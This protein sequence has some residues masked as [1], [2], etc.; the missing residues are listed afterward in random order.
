VGA[1]HRADR[2]VGRLDRLDPVAQGLVDGVLE[3]R[4]AGGHRPDLGAEQPHPDH[5]E[6]LA[7]GV[8]L[9]HVD[10]ALLAEEG[11]DGGGGHTVLAGAGLGDHPRLA[12]PA[13]QQVLA[14]GVVELVGA[15]VEQVLPL[16]PH[17]HAQLLREPPGLEQRGRAAGV[18]APELVQLGGEGWVGDGVLEGLG[19]LVEGG[20]QDLGDEAPAPLPEVAE[21][22]GPVRDLGGTGRAGRLGEQP[23]R[24]RGGSPTGSPRRP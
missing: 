3:G 21:R 8:L 20:H 23:V 6:V 18:V 7:P 24:H 5:V 4:G 15:G 13:G 22:V 10:D 9:A 19:E 14:E 11:G 17:P 2:V 16:E 1:D 12:H